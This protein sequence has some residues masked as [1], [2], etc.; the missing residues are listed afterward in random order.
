VSSGYLGDGHHGRGVAF[1]VLDCECDRGAVGLGVGG[2]MAVCWVYRLKSLKYISTNPTTEDDRVL[3]LPQVV[4]EVCDSVFA[5][6]D[7]LLLGLLSIIFLPIDIR[8]NRGNLA[9][10]QLDQLPSTLPS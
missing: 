7:K 3:L 10:C 9:I 1:F 5:V 8:Q 2:G 4:S 6:A